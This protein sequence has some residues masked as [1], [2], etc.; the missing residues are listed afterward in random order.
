MGFCGIF[1]KKKLRQDLP[2]WPPRWLSLRM[3][4]ARNGNYGA[5]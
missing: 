5:C 2:A 3:K 4:G 1:K